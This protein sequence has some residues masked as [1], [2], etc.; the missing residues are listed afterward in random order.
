LPHYEE[1]LHVWAASTDGSNIISVTLSGNTYPTVFKPQDI[2]G[3][4]DTF[5]ELFYNNPNTTPWMATT[6]VNYGQILITSTGNC[7][8][9]VTIGTGPFYT[10]SSAPTSTNPNA[11]FYN[12]TAL[13]Q[14]YCQEEYLGMFRYSANGGMEYYFANVGLQQVCHKTL[15]TGNAF[16]PPGGTTISSLILS[17][18]KGMFLNLAINRADSSAYL[19]GMKMI[20]GGYIWRCITAG[21]SSSTPPYSGS[22]TVGTSTVTDGTAV[23]LCIF[24][25]YASQQYLWF[26]TENDFITYKG[27]DS[28]DSYAS[29]AFNLIARYL[30]ITLDTTFLGSN[31]PQ[32]DG[33]GGYLT[34]KTLIDNLAYFNLSTQIANFLTYVF[35][36]GVDP[37]DGSAYAVQFT[38]DNC[39]VVSGYRDLAYICGFDGDT[40]GQTTALANSLY[41]ADGVFALFNTTYNLFISYY[42]QDITTWINDTEVAWYP[43]LQCQFFAEYYNV[44]TITDDVRKIIRYNVSLRWPNYLQ[45]KALDSYPNNQMGYMAANQWQDPIKAES[46]VEKTQRYFI[47]GGSIA[48]GAITNGGPS[49]IAEW[50]YFLATK[51][52]LI[53]PVQLLNINSNNIN[54]A[55][56]DGSVTS[57]NPAA[58]RNS[59]TLTGVTPVT[60]ADTSVLLTSVI[61]FTLRTEIGA[62][63]SYPTA[64]PTPGTGFT[65]HGS[66]GD[67]SIYNYVVL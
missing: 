53:A 26:D 52:A 34:Y 36:N 12:G 57:Y 23:F 66:S 48:Q 59:V 7:Y 8:L 60:V 56:Q 58:S 29:T 2:D 1:K 11:P 63:G 45:D 44:P 25:S 13:L 16:T 46:F 9:V 30:A 27:P 40:S 61:L 67:N 39:G 17:H 37:N 51:D 54:Y 18:I 42:G 31:S 4:I 65:V 21:T 49:D 15:I 22:Y 50:G 35:Q 55:N 32:P 10:G 28:T 43:N 41:I 47:T 20:A 14:Y 38:E 3:S 24:T 64:V 33:F 5:A 62:Q 19:F 6:A